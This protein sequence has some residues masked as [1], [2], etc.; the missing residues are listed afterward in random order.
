MLW[1][2]PLLRGQEKG[3]CCAKIIHLQQTIQIL[4]ALR[5]AL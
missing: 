1:R 3:K 2:Y 4:K 5:E